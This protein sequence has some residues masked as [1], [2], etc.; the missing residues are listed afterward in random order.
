MEFA[1]A[2]P[3]VARLTALVHAPA[4]DGIDPAA[5]EW[6]V[7]LGDEVEEGPAQDLRRGEEAIVGAIVDRTGH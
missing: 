1:E 4:L 3:A 5:D 2:K 6:L 7:S